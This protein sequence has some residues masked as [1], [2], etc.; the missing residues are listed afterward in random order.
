MTLTTRCRASI[1][2]SLLALLT[3]V[4]H[5][6]TVKLAVGQ[7]GFWDTSIAV[8]GERA[9]FFKQEGLDLE[10][11]YTD[12]GAQTQQAVI[13]GGVQVGI[14]TGSLGVLAAAVKGAP[15]RIIEAEWHGASDLF[16]YARTSSA[17]QSMKDAAGHSAAFSAAGSSSNL[18][19]LALL[20]QAGVK[21]QPTPTG[22]A[23]A[24]LTQVMSGQIDIGWS[25]PPIGLAEEK[26]G[27]IRIVGRGTDVPAL[28]DQTTR[29]NIANAL[30]LKD[31]RDVAIRFARAYDRSLAFAYSDPKAVAWYAE[32]MGIDTT[33]ARQIRDT[34]Y[35]APAMQDDVIKGLD[36]TLR[37][38]LNDKRVPP[39]T[40]VD[41]LKPGIDLLPGAAP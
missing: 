18:V 23:G 17:I 31:H 9:G 16:W 22:G 24:T 14:A 38:M 36:A 13:S 8:W 7:K 21:A 33:L 1:L 10:I 39:G 37:D 11:L 5:S 20:A 34:Y 3:G 41:Q 35:P 12:G 19:L 29:V 28:A 25:V 40:T 4:A 32:G 2:A 26:A 30:W 6:E 15:V 27:Q